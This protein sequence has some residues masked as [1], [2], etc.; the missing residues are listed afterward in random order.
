MQSFD[1]ERGVK[2]T[3]AYMMA[4]SLTGLNSEKEGK[5]IQLEIFAILFVQTCVQQNGFDQNSRPRMPRELR[6][7][8]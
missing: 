8:N 2:C 1:C 6:I 3:W 5:G 7:Y 4:K